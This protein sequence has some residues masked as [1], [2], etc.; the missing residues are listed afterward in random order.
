MKLIGVF[1]G[2]GAQSVGMLGALAAEHP[3]VLET[4]ETA[5][6]ILGYDLWRLVQD[7][8][9]GDLNTTVRTQ[10]A[11]LTAG[12]AV[13]RV[14]RDNSG[15]VPAV[16]AGH[17]LGE[18]T[19]LVCAGA[20]EFA[21]AIDLVVFRAT[22]MQNAV[23]Q[24]AGAMAALI[25]LDD[26]AVRSSCTEAAS[27]GVVEAVNYNAPGQVVIAGEKAAVELAGERARAAGAKRVIPLSV[28]VPS[29]CA[30]MR[31]AAETMAT[32]LEEVDIATPEIPVLHNVD[33]TTHTE[34]D[35]IRRALTEQLYRPV[36]W[37]ETIRRAQADGVEAVLELG[38]GKVLAGLNRRIERR[39]PVHSVQDPQ[40]LDRALTDWKEG[41][42]A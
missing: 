21:D 18:Y 25:G 17:S 19:A 39:M 7:G 41:V 5:S 20:L 3:S 11:L 15:A 12:V 24:G 23:P 8:P 22:S 9:E 32:R 27:A 2:Q 31:P 6:G 36:R 33:V 35:E 30:L 38:P 10:P 28:S 42:A 40:S 26:D 4:F 1:P 34:P 13:W 37:V 29:H 16:L 14:W